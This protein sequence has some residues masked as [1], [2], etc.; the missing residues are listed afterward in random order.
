MC[1]VNTTQNVHLS[2]HVTSKCQHGL[3]F[4]LGRGT[5]EE[6]FRTLLDSNLLFTPLLD[7]T[8]RLHA[9]TNTANTESVRDLQRQ[10]QLVI[11]EWEAATE[12]FSWIITGTAAVT[13]PPDSRNYICQCTEEIIG[14]STL[15][16]C[17][18]EWQTSGIISEKVSSVR[19]ARWRNARVDK[20][21]N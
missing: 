7:M 8:T 19:S 21:N 15:N 20:H 13:A 14:G 17:V 18:F 12:V 1:T 3:D 16:S 4:F 10:E 9:E 6:T 11:S 5:G 2:A